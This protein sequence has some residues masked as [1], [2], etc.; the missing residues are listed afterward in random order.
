MPIQVESILREIDQYEDAD[1][2]RIAFDDF[3][4]QVILRIYVKLFDRSLV[5]QSKAK[6]RGKNWRTI[7]R[8]GAKE[9]Q[10][11]CRRYDL[12]RILSP[13]RTA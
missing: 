12:W 8:P 4:D 5:R 9:V 13:K 2:A 11:L 1:R 6:L 7:K 10:L 3:C